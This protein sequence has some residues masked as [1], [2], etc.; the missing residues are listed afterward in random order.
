MSWSDNSAF[1]PGFLLEVSKGNVPG[2]EPDSFVAASTVLDDVA[3]K[4]MWDITTPF[5]RPTGNES[6]ELVFDDGADTALGTGA[7]AVAVSGLDSNFNVRTEI[8]ATSGAGTIAVP[9]S[10]WRYPRPMFVVN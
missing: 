8:I 2:H 10:D 4:T 1:T 7:R 5:V 3:F 9:N 6:W